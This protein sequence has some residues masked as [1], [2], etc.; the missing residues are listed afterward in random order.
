MSA[1]AAIEL[2]GVGKAFGSR[3]VIANLDVTVHAGELV[4]ITGPSGAGKSTVLNL[5][6]LLERP[7]AGT[8]RLFGRPAPSMS[9]ARGRRL[10]RTRLG[11][12][13]QNYAL[14]DSDTA[15]ANLAVAQTFSGAVSG[16]KKAARL[17]ALARVGL[18]GMADRRVYELS[19]GEQQRLAIARLLLKP[20]DL[21]LADEPTGSLDADNRDR[22][23]ALL[24]ELRDAGKTVVIVTHDPA[25]AQRCDRVVM[26]GG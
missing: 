23:L 7:D 1:E 3:R 21:I 24:S 8:I 15:A 19:G 13:F 20:C 11:Y 25:V 22:V 14:I 9:S 10:L 26:L 17:A 12:L 6:G 5:I 2:S 4:A 18:E 16:G